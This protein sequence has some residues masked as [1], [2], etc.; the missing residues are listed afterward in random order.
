MMLLFS[1]LIQTAKEVSDKVMTIRINN[2]SLGN[3]NTMGSKQSVR[4]QNRRRRKSKDETQN[5]PERKKRKD[6][7][8]FKK[9]FGGPAIKLNLNNTNLT[10]NNNVL[11]HCKLPIC[12]MPMSNKAKLINESLITQMNYKGSD[13]QTSNFNTHNTVETV[14]GTSRKDKNH[15]MLSVRP[16]GE[17]SQMMNSARI[18]KQ[19]RLKKN[20]KRISTNNRYKPINITEEDEVKA[21][22]LS[23]GKP[24]RNVPNINTSLVVNRN[25]FK[26]NL[27]TGVAESDQRQDTER[28]QTQDKKKLIQSIDVKSKI[29]TLKT[30]RPT[31]KKVYSNQE[32]QPE[33]QTILNILNESQS[34]AKPSTNVQPAKNFAGRTLEANLGT[35]KLTTNSNAVAGLN[36]T[37]AQ[38]KSGRSPTH[39]SFTNPQAPKT[40]QSENP[41]FPLGAG[42]A[43]K[44]FMS[45]IS[46]FEKGEILDYRK[47][48]FLGLE[49]KKIKGSPLLNPNYGYDNDKGDYKTVMKDHIAYRYEVLETLG[50]GSFG[51]ALKC[52]DHKTNEYVCLKIIRNQEKF[53]YQ[54]S[55]EVKVLQHIKDTD[56]EDTTNL[57]KMRDYFVF[58]NHVCIIFELLSMNLYEFIKNTDFRG[59]S[60]GLIRRF[61]IQLLH[62][63]KFIKEQEIIH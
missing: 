53:Q 44:L 11:K 26:K 20:L 17:N 15:I 25:N 16:A 35:A 7:R 5:V 34:E 3:L 27:I 4:S 14:R 60:M 61:A 38:L 41:E 40:V 48:Y 31:H 49:A 57:V 18:N 24:K 46:D 36:K 43:L 29:Q 63:L 12:D 2:I 1:I 32:S 54:A 8:L 13:I 62:S 45:K 28:V 42:K 6:S 58:R 33:V 37:I 51:Q 19:V 59:V 52:F 50:K 10:I 56:P 55:V 22:S 23:R 39:S 21:Q 9:S 30:S 47:V